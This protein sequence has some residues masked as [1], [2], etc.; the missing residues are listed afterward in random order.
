[1]NPKLRWAIDNTDNPKILEILVE[2]S[3]LKSDEAQGAMLDIIE[4]G[5]FSK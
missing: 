1:M 2:I 3:K 5:Y 4:R